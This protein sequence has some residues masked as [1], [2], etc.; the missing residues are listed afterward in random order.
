MNHTKQNKPCNE[1]EIVLNGK[2]S[3]R[4]ERY[5]KAGWSAPFSFYHFSSSFVFGPPTATV[6]IK[7]R[8]LTQF[9]PARMWVV[10]T[11]A[12]RARERLVLVSRERIR[13]H[14]EATRLFPVGVPR[15][16]WT[17]FFSRIGSSSDEDISEQQDPFATYFNDPHKRPNY[18][19]PFPNIISFWWRIIRY[20]E[21]ENR[22]RKDDPQVLGYF[23]R[24]HIVYK[25]LCLFLQGTVACNFIEWHAQVKDE[26]VKV[27]FLK[28][29]TQNL[30]GMRR[31]LPRKGNF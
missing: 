18:T 27:W 14:L 12:R 31:L 26:F 16:I 9:F 1:A 23:Y 11:H 19:H 22:W 7:L 17:F 8:R 28:I 25:I 6:R 21:Y 30:A 10:I 24:L 4:Y 2:E 20:L 3:K 5:I 29:N 13:A 15:T